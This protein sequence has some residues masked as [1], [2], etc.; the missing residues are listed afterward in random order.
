MLKDIIR[1][2]FEFSP[3]SAFLTCKEYHFSTGCFIHYGIHNCLVQ[4][5]RNKGLEEWVPK[6]I[7][8]KD[9]KQELF[10]ED[11]EG[12]FLGTPNIVFATP[13]Y[14]S[15]QRVPILG[16]IP[17]FEDTTLFLP[18]FFSFEATL[19]EKEEWFRPFS[20]NTH[21]VIS[22]SPCGRYLVIVDRMKQ[23]IRFFENGYSG[24]KW[25]KAFDDTDVYLPFVR[26]KEN[27]FLVVYEDVLLAT[28]HADHLIYNKQ[29]HGED[30]DPDYSWFCLDLT[31]KE[32]SSK[33]E[34]II[35]PEFDNEFLLDLDCIAGDFG[36]IFP[37]PWIGPDKKSRRL[38]VYVNGNVVH[39]NGLVQGKIDAIENK[40]KQRIHST[41]ERCLFHQQHVQVCIVWG[42][43]RE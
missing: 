2:I 26:W 31:G 29:D 37:K 24:Q 39:S 6:P 36:F 42:P 17:D 40:M 43:F 14:I 33:Y 30:F 15:H 7:T 41:M 3:Q 12:T 25:E 34:D 11:H 20:S 16:S 8:Y 13:K 5:W 38:C 28:W 10:A 23:V 9:T 4:S 32:I 22:Q 1:F 27:S 21:A 18:T 35:V 19:P